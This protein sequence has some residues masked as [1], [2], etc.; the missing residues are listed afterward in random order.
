[1]RSSPL[2]YIKLVKGTVNC[3][4]DKFM[5]DGGALDGPRVLSEEMLEHDINAWPSN[6]LSL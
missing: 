6:N 4:C 5:E 1:M 2:L 3:N